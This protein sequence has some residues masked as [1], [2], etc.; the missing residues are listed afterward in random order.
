M[1][2]DIDIVSGLSLSRADT[3]T[4]YGL[5]LSIGMFHRMGERA[6]ETEREEEEKAER[7]T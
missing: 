7:R 5:I 4:C 3:H 6:I 1:S 2:Y